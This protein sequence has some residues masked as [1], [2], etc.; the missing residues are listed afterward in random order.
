LRSLRREIDAA[1]GEDA[2]PTNFQ[3]RVWMML[4]SI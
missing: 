2:P 4:L 3:I 1:V